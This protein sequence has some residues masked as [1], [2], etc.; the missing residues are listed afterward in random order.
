MP[1][2]LVAGVDSSTQ[3]TKVVLVDVDDG[4]LVATGRAAHE[5]TGVHG[6][7][8]SDPTRW[9]AAL[10]EALA[11]AGHGADVAA[12][13][14][15]GQQHGLVVADATGTPLRPAILWN[16]TRAAAEARDLVDALGGG[17]AW[18]QAVGSVPVAAFTVSSWAWLRRY[19]PAVA[20]A[21]RAVRLPHDFLTEQLT[22][23]AVT[24][25]GDASGTGWWSPLTGAY[26]TEILDLP[27]VRLDPAPLPGVA[28]WQRPAGEV[29]AQAAGATG[30]P[31]GALV[32][33]G[34]GDNMA[35]AL[36]LGLR[37]GEPVMSFGTSGTA[38]VVSTAPTADPTG[39]VA[40]FADA[41]DRYLPLACTLNCTLAVDRVAAWLGLDREAVEPGGAVVVLPYLDGERTPDLP[42]APGTITGLRHTSTPGHILLAAYEGAVSSLL[43]ALGRVEALSSPSVAD[44]PLLLVGG[45]SRGR[46][47]QDVTARLSGRTL[48]VPD[49]EELVALGA[50][51]QAAGLLTGERPDEIARRWGTRCGRTV[52][53]PPR[54]EATW[55]RIRSVRAGLEAY[56]HAPPGSP[57]EG[58]TTGTAST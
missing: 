58:Y 40:G 56:N 29:T 28:A 36:G 37:P 24:D 57:A 43:D 25:R 12:L 23:R 4:G 3:A 55:A 9:W 41:T 11:M 52:E 33:V 49:A 53:A 22:G 50:A 46:V 42:H 30:L 17:E 32:G 16:D 26:V 35:A 21:T 34:T 39:V 18:A 54:D 8:E 2:R 47:W 5:V 1:R 45:G 15:G 13:A 20:D 31:A 48:H 10:G 44:A 7:R 27:L 38:Y 6:V 51:A 19:E 14:I